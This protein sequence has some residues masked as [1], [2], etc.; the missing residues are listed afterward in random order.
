MWKCFDL[1]ALDPYWE[2]SDKSSAETDPRVVII[3]LSFF[4]YRIFRSDSADTQ[5]MRDNEE[6]NLLCVSVFVCNFCYPPEHHVCSFVVM[7]QK[8]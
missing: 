3:V 7:V 4:Q 1:V 5:T 2:I 6:E 8:I